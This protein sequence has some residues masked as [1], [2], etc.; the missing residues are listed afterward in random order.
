VTTL[1]TIDGN[2]RFSSFADPQG[3]ARSNVS[4]NLGFQRKLFNKRLIAS[5][6]LIDPFR[7]QRFTTYTYGT[8]FT[9]ENFNSSNTTNVRISLAYQINPSKPKS[10]ISDR[11]K[12]EIL[13]K[14]KANK[15]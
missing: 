7:T 10:K 5:L 14:V 3:R 6:N 9:L 13:N 2:V 11:Q 1:T 15:T 4:M 8:N 12:K